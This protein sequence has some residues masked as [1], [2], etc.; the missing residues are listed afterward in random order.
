M[1]ITWRSV[2]AAAAVALLAA[3]CG[4]GPPGGGLTNGEPAMLGGPEKAAVRSD[5]PTPEV[6]NGEPIA[7]GSS[8]SPAGTGT[9]AGTGGRGRGELPSDSRKGE[10]GGSPPATP[11]KTEASGENGAQGATKPPGDIKVGN[12]RSPQ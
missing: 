7:E 12:P 1:T 11:P 2:C 10:H 6:S 4:T 3:G 8:L 5:L 9:N